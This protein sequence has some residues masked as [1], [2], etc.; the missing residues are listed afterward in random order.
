MILRFLANGS[1]YDTDLTKS[2]HKGRQAYL[3]FKTE[4]IFYS[5]PLWEILELGNC[6]PTDCSSQGNK[7]GN[8]YGESGI[9]I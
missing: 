4:Y 3:V 1:K 7:W 2:V 9:D 6:V 5:S 8:L